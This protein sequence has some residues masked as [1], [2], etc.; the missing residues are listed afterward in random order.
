[1]VEN[2]VHKLFTFCEDILLK[3]SFFKLFEKISLWLFLNQN[4]SY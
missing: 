3:Y 4:Q 1:M 2:E